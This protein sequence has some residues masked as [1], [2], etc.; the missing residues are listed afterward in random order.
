MADLNAGAGL[1]AGVEGAETRNAQ[2]AEL[3]TQ[4]VAAVQETNA[5]VQFKEMTLEHMKRFTDELNSQDT[6]LARLRKTTA[7]LQA[8]IKEAEDRASIT[9]QVGDKFM[10]QTASRKPFGVSRLTKTTCFA[11]ST[12][13][14][15]S[16][17]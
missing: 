8:A 13:H 14:S 11:T 7:S 17:K 12:T 10:V 4:L 5:L 2:L 3:K 15:Y 16:L 6:E 1:G 9:V